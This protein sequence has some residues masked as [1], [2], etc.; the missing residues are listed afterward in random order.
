VS[1]SYYMCG[2]CHKPYF[3]GL[4]RCEQNMEEERDFNPEDLVR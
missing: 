2:R 3:G 1:P 4:R